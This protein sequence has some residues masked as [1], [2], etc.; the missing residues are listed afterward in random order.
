M[1][2]EQNALTALQNRAKTGSGS[3]LIRKSAAFSPYKKTVAHGT[4]PVILKSLMPFLLRTLL[5]VLIM[6]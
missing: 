6:V 4:D 3:T 5:W 1:T 2:I